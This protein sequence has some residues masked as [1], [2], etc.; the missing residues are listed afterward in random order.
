MPSKPPAP[1]PLV[2]SFAPELEARIAA[3]LRRRLGRDG[4]AE[5]LAGYRQVLFALATFIGNV[6]DRER[7]AD[8]ASRPTSTD[9]CP[10]PS[11]TP[12]SPRKATTDKPPPSNRRSIGP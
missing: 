10:E 7:A 11:S 5:E 3:L 2:P 8:L 6:I 1:L 12:G 9:P 4:T